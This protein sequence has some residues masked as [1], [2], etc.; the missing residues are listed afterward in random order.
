MTGPH[1]R[2]GARDGDIAALCALTAAS[3]TAVIG[4]PMM[5]DLLRAEPAEGSEVHLV[6]E[7]GRILGYVHVATEAGQA[8]LVSIAVHPDH[9]RRGIGSR[10]L[11]SALST[12]RDAGADLLR[13]SGRPRGYVAPGV[14][15]DRD[16]G[17]A[18]FLEAHGAAP[19]GTALAMHR[20][21][22]DLG[23]PAAHPDIAVEPCHTD[24][25]P[26][27]LALIREQLAPDW[28]DTLGRYG[29]GGG[30]PGRILIA[31][32]PGGALLGFACWGVVGRDPGRFGPFGVVPAA[33]GRGAGAALLD[34]ALLRMAGEGIGHA[35]FQWTAPGSAAHRLY[36]SRGLAPLRTFTP[37][38]LSTG[39]PAD[40]GPQEGL[41]R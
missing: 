37:Y 34:S 10:L 32:A 9:R 11:G 7:D 22:H 5:R 23:V 24:E 13:I 4:E 8:W 41:S 14:D 25:L 28:A 26:D 6:E 21:L 35:W 1:L 17:T 3:G 40:A 38:T 18:A 12:A 29:A 19:A 33:R 39:R 30:D 2:R 31:R 36:T 16:P 15:R 20:T 27:L